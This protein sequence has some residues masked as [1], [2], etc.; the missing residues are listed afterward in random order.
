MNFDR[1]G[2][3]EAIRM[4]R[5]NANTEIQTL[6]MKFVFVCETYLF[7]NKEKTKKKLGKTQ[8]SSSIRQQQLVILT[9][10]MYFLSS[11]IKEK[12]MKI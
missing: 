9:E 12:Q 10:L 11:I 4:G 2:M 5:V 6:K 7:S 3:N 8:F 1:F